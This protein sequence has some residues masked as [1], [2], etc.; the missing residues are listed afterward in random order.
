MLFLALGFCSEGLNFGLCSRSFFNS[1]PKLLTCWVTGWLVV[2]CLRD[3]QIA[4]LSGWRFSLYG[5][6]SF[7][8]Y[9]HPFKSLTKGTGSGSESGSG[10]GAGAGRGQSPGRRHR[11][12]LLHAK[13]KFQ[14][15][16]KPFCIINLLWYQ[17]TFALV[18]GVSKGLATFWTD[19][20]FLASG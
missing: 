11:I 9:F 19:C 7:L 2:G 13:W 18:P 10:T 20:N 5:W 12:P 15:L 17:I 14:R 3:C 6:L 8:K 16:R 4:R 1:V